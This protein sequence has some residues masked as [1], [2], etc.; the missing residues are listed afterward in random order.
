L[1]EPGAAEFLA[2]K[3]S[4]KMAVVLPSDGMRASGEPASDAELPEE[5]PAWSVSDESDA[6][7]SDTN[8]ANEPGAN[9]ADANEPDANAADANAPDANASAASAAQAPDEPDRIDLTAQ[10]GDDNDAACSA[11]SALKAALKSKAPI[12]AIA[13]TGSMASRATKAAKATRGQKPP[14][15]APTKVTNPAKATKDPLQARKK[16]TTPDVPHPAAKRTRR[17]DDVDEMSRF[18][19]MVVNR[20]DNYCS[21]YGFNAEYLPIVQFVLFFSGMN[22]RKKRPAERFYKAER[23]GLEQAIAIEPYIRDFLRMVCEATDGVFNDA[24]AYAADFKDESPSS[25]PR[26]I[27]LPLDPP[28]DLV[29]FMQENETAKSDMFG[30]SK[31]GLVNRFIILAH[32]VTRYRTQPERYNYRTC[33]GMSASTTREHSA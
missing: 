13:S 16:R 32:A 14:A 2:S 23:D 8:D 24:M 19:D 15:K 33:H 12:V 25:L 31:P 9:A 21:V 26:S 29:K 1:T 6:D 4:L 27:L 18:W 20:I 17:G 28:D 22:T 3:R 11:Q 30:D 5:T 10:S 7:E